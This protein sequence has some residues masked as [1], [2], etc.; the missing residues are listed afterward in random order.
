MRGTATKMSCGQGPPEPRL[1]TQCIGLGIF[2]LSCYHQECEMDGR[3]SSSLHLGSKRDSHQC[4]TV[5]YAAFCFLPGSPHS[6]PCKVPFS[7]QPANPCKMFHFI[8][9]Q[10]S[11]VLCSAYVPLKNFHFKTCSGKQNLLTVS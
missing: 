6:L 10:S 8:P 11:F 2:P 4:Q 9:L 1:L 7:A 5:G 3:D